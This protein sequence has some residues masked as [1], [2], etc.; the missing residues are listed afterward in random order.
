MVTRRISRLIAARRRT[1][2]FKKPGAGLALAV[3][4]LTI[5]AVLS[6]RALHVP[7]GAPPQPATAPSS[8]PWPQKTL[9]AESPSLVIDAVGSCPAGCVQPAA[10]CVI[11]GNISFRTGERI[12]HL[13]GQQ[14]YE[15]T[16]IRPEQGERWFCTEGE[17]QANGWRKSK[18]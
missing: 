4:I 2:R 14:Y 17:A 12:Y 5:L 11:K 10:G 15:K 6:S 16:V 7:A 9:L 1:P 8:I 13:P 3:A 18:R